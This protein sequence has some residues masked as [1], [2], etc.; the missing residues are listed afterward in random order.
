MF[1]GEFNQNVDGQ[2]PESVQSVRQFQEITRE[3][4]DHIVAQLV[5][6]DRVHE[7]GAMSIEA[8][9]HHRLG[10]N[11]F[12]RTCFAITEGDT[13]HSAIYVSKS[14]GSLR[15]DRDFSGN[16][17]DILAQPVKANSRS[18]ESLIFYSI[19]NISNAQGVGQALVSQLHTHLG[20]AFSK[21]KASTLSPLRS[22]DQDFSEKDRSRFIA[23]PVPEQKKIVLDYL[24]T[25]ENL[26]QQ[27]HMGNG[28]RIADIKLQSGDKSLHPKTGEEIHHMAMVNYAYDVSPAVLMANADAFKS[29]K[30]A[31]RI[32]DAD[33][34]QSRQ[35]IARGIFARVS[36]MLLEETGWTDSD[37]TRATSAPA[38][39]F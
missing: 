11:G 13:V 14:Y 5:G 35:T 23:L 27:F 3:A 20:N 39:R 25:S 1:S 12:D 10:G 37:P 33:P 19:S 32:K 22:F 6:H 36:S 29:V 28:A 8:L 16:V 26:V 24:L 31:L 34:V 15:S 4:P 2:Q 30:K 38:F 7:F 18:P 17:A 9:R 21:A